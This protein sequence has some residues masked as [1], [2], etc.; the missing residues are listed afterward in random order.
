MNFTE[1]LT[2]VWHFISLK[3]LLSLD[4]AYFLCQISTLIIEYYLVLCY[5]KS[6]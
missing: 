3:T 6:I 4:M 1:S 2:G 5:N